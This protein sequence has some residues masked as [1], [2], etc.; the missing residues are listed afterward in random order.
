MVT[1]KTAHV[2]TH[3]GFPMSGDDGVSMLHVREARTAD[4]ATINEIISASVESWGLPARVK[5]LA[6]PSLLY[7][8][9]DFEHM[10]ML[11]MENAASDGIG[12]AAW[13]EADSKTTAHG[14][15][16]VLHGIYLLPAYQR[17][18]L[19][20]KLFELVEQRLLGESHDLITV[21]AWRE[22][23]G[24]FDSLGFAP[25]DPDDDTYP[26]SMRKSIR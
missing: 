3:S 23:R 18:G 14:R 8:A 25:L 4:L 26:K 21:R 11:V 20:R 15:M 1:D 2:R 12:V 22:S 24:F 7:R 5:R 10:A 19:G 17:H 6:L 16:V 13:E 9:D